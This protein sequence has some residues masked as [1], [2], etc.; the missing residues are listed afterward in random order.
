MFATI[1]LADTLKALFTLILQLDWL[2][3][4]FGLHGKYFMDLMLHSPLLVRPLFSLLCFLFL[5]FQWRLIFQNPNGGGLAQASSQA[6]RF[7]NAELRND[8][9]ICT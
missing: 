7:V 6:R 2:E 3:T 4:L 8:G 5:D 1:L 9:E